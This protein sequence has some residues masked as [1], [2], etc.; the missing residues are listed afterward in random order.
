MS[1]F[2][3]PTLPASRL[4]SS[5]R[6]SARNLPAYCG[7]R[8]VL[9]ASQSL[10]TKNREA[11]WPPDFVI[12][13]LPSPLKSPWIISAVQAGRHLGVT[14]GL[15]R[16]QKRSLPLW[17][18]QRVVS[19][20]RRSMPDDLCRTRGSTPC[21]YLH[22][23]SSPACNTRKH[24]RSTPSSMPFVW[25]PMPWCSPPKIACAEPRRKNACCSI[26]FS[27]SGF[28]GA[29][30]EREIPGFPVARPNAGPERR[31]TLPQSLDRIASPRIAGSLASR[32]KAATL[33]GTAGR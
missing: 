24:S 14:P 19:P 31:E 12:F 23:A 33:S 4:E 28:S 18:E 17:S 29:L 22:R 30:G 11:I 8:S 16:D 32:G 26:A 27:C 15:V 21:R 9:T 2:P 6:R 25:E 10:P 13:G 1:D 7:S 5:Q 20:R 3:I